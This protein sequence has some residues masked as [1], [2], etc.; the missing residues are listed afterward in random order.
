MNTEDRAKLEAEYAA[1][2]AAAI[3]LESEWRDSAFIDVASEIAG[4]EVR[5]LTLQDFQLLYGIGSPI[6]CGGKVSPADIL[7]FL[8][9]ISVERKRDPSNKTRDAF[10][11]K[12][13]GLLYVET[14]SAIDSYLERTFIDA[15]KGSKDGEPR[16]KV[17]PNAQVVHLLAKTY[18]WSER[19]ILSLPLV[20]L[21]QSLRL[22]GDDFRI[23][24]G[25]G[26]ALSGSRVDALWAEYLQ[27]LNGP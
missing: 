7:Q 24:A 2:I 22:I 26:P 13:K 21:Y 5:D 6:I 11:K 8:W 10:I 20:R 9:V 14:L 27:K 4:I 23:E 25:K 15:P 12:G 19:E 18:N 1:K 3:A 17:S 16:V